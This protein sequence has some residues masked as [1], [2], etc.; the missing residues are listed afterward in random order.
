M[1][2]IW[3]TPATWAVNQ[4]VT[5]DDLNEQ[6]RDNLEFLK[7]PPTGAYK[8]NQ[9]SDYGTSSTSFVNVDATN[10]AFSLDI[11]GG[12]VLMGFQGSVLGNT[13]SRRVYFDVDV[14]TLGRLG[15]DDGLVT[16]HNPNGS[17][18]RIVL[19]AFTYLLTGLPAGTHIF[20]LQWKV[21]NGSAIL[22]AGAGTANVDVH[23]QF[24]VREI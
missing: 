9:G 24:W 18:A 19:A 10:W 6:L 20:R 15:A 14:N 13:T 21:D 4:L 1:P 23:P 12:A 7:G 17:D 22:Y 11:A 5:A 16:V 8:A 2:A 3:T